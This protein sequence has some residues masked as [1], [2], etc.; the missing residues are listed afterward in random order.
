MFPKT[1]GPK[2]AARTFT[3]FLA[4]LEIP[5]ACLIWWIKSW[6]KTIFIYFKF[7]VLFVIIMNLWCA[8]LRVVHRKENPKFNQ[9]PRKN[10]SIM[11]QHTQQV[12]KVTSSESFPAARWSP[13]SK[14]GFPVQHHHATRKIWMYSWKIWMYSWKITKERS[15]DIVSAL[16]AQRAPNTRLT[17]LPTSCRLH[18][19][20]GEHR[21]ISRIPEFA[22]LS[23]IIQRTFDC[24]KVL[25]QAKHAR[26]L[27]CIHGCILGRNQFRITS[28]SAGSVIN[29][30][31]H[32][33]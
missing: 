6:F 18:E 5:K 14:F 2:G 20:L 32:R 9:F 15:E 13:R 8:T 1:Y 23:F 30:V 24:T 3:L 27:L 16:I 21:T 10:S 33:Y 29:V 22:E 31:L 7:L 26:G 11:N 12:D 19:I 17:E 25:S 4:S 28:F